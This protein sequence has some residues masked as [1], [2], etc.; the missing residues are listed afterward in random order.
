MFHMA[1][2]WF[3]SVPMATVI[4]YPLPFERWTTENDISPTT[5]TNTNHIY[6]SP[7]PRWPV[8][9][10]NGCQSFLCLHYVQQ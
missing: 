6:N 9:A 2:L 5:P 3:H 10:Q 8:F 4:G 1:M 7:Y